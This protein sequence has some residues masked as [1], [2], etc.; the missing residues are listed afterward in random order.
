MGRIR[1]LFAAGF[2]PAPLF[3]EF[4]HRVQEELFSISSDQTRAKFGKNRVIKARIREFQVE[5]H[6]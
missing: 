4:E 1:A 3:K 6:T 2:E 5:A